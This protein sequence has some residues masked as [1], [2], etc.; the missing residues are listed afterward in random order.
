L[1]RKQLFEIYRDAEERFR[2]RLRSNNEIIYVSD[3]YADKKSCIKAIENFKNDVSDSK[4]KEELFC[5]ILFIDIVGYSLLSSDQQVNAFTKL[6]RTLKSLASFKQIPTTNRIVISTGDGFAIITYAERSAPLAPLEMIIELHRS[7][8]NELVSIPI[9]AGIHCGMNSKVRDYDG[10][11]NILGPAINYAQRVM[12]IGDKH[13]ILLS[14][15]YYQ[16]VLIGKTQY[17]NMC[18]P[19]GEYIAK[20]NVPIRIV[21]VFVKDD[22]GNPEPP[23]AGPLTIKKVTGAPITKQ[24][25]EIANKEL[26]IE[27]IYKPFL[28]SIIRIEDE[29]A[30]GENPNLDAFEKIRKN[31]LY[32]KIDEKLRE[33]VKDAFRE[34]KDYC[35]IYLVSAKKIDEIIRETIEE[36]FRKSQDLEKY[37]SGGY[38]VIYRA[39]IGNKRVGTENLRSS[40]IMSKT[41]I[42]RLLKKRETRNSEI[43]SLISGHHVDRNIADQLVE[44]AFEKSTQ[45]LDVMRLTL[46]RIYL[47]HLIDSIKKTLIKLI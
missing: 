38:E 33:D 41:P 43:D 7:L 19:L 21:N 27:S 28:D 46:I 9:R 45:D 47:D 34:L 11:E 4:I 35:N 13:H 30:N 16:T 3:Q 14:A 8:K 39:F 29:I 36:K 40:L 42:R 17:T 18:H 32:L 6:D 2:F 26:L 20:H 25:D 24:H 23:S 15:E 31:G 22:F 37:R 10:D 5:F 44:S 12:S 1:N